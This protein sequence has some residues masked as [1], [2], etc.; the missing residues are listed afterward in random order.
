MADELD[1]WLRDIAGVETELEHINTDAENS[2][3]N[4]SNNNIEEPQDKLPFSSVSEKVA[5]FQHYSAFTSQAV[6][7][8]LQAIHTGL[9]HSNSAHVL[10]SAS[11]KLLEIIGNRD[12]VLSVCLLALHQS[13]EASEFLRRVA[14][15]TIVDPLRSQSGAVLAQKKHLMNAGK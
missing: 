14:N 3:N 7:C 6:E 4:N 15:Q 2:D 12:P 11:L 10:S 13:V 8:L 5:R 1:A 9:N